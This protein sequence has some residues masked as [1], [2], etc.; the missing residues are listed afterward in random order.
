MPH[1]ARTL[2]KIG[3]LFLIVMVGLL[4]QKHATEPSAERISFASIC[5]ALEFNAEWMGIYLK[6]EK[7]GYAV[8]T[9]K[10]V[11]DC[12]EISDHAL[13]C[14]N[15]AGSKQR[16]ESRLTSS[17]DLDFSLRSFL[18]SLTSNNASFSLHGVVDGRQLRVS[19]FSG[20][21]ENRTTIPLQETPCVT[22]TIKPHLLRQGIAVGSQYRLPYFDPSTM[23]HGEMLI[24]VEAHEKII[25]GDKP[26]L[27][28]RVRESYHGIE[29]LVW[30]TSEGTVL[31]EES[32][33]GLTLVREGRDR[34]L[35]GSWT[36][37]SEQD[38]LAATAISTTQHI[39]A[40]RSVR[41]LE[42]QLGGIDLEAFDLSGG[43]QSLAG[44]LLLID[45]EAPGD[46]ATYSL[47]CAQ[48]ELRQFLAASPLIQSDHPR[49]IQQAAE[50]INGSN[51]A[52]IAARLLL[53][54]VYKYL[55]KKPTVSV[56]S[57]VQV[58]DLK[59]GDCNE[60]A[61]LFAALARSRGI[62]TRICSG[63]V[64]LEEKFYYHAWAEIFMGKWVAVDPAFNQFPADATHIRLVI[65]DSTEQ[66]R[67]L[68]VI[69]QLR[70]QV[71]QYS[72]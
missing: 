41:H 67:L 51:D 21:N 57:A 32:P 11:G 44:N 15:L 33:L 5:D 3:L 19:I 8:S 61:A 14:L 25:H 23:A 62:P 65:G 10:R 70:L 26:V 22:N 35:A 28:Y 43:R 52:V 20:R 68:N 24:T 48:E 16:I 71:M 7:V 47:P 12:Y 37:G 64:R 29:A 46:L 58:L 45:Q 69:G 38:F 4:M 30:V 31:K 27:A 34:A 63:L 2:L 55:D 56:P 39:L 54:W 40:P 36:K 13:I 72:S 18:F 42:I 9:T 66:I 1:N 59:A 49:I 53:Q 50:I 17:V 60:H 6:D